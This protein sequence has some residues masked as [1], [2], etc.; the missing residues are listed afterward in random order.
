MKKLSVFVLFLLIGQGPILANTITAKINGMV[1]AFCA[2]GIEKKFKSEDSVEKVKVDLDAK[3]VKIDLKTG[4][5][6]DAET[7]K[8]IIVGAGYEVES[9]DVASPKQVTDTGSN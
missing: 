5:K 9:I 1:C 6:M 4:A 7:V 2:Q 8:K 3:T